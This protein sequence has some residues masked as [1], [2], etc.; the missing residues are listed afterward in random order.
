MQQ[1][2]PD[3][4][5]PIGQRISFA[6]RCDSPAEVDAVYARMIAAGHQGRQAPWDAF[7]GQ[8]YAMLT[9][10]DGNRVDLFADQPAA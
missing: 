10:P 5:R 8:R 4:V 6:C 3:W 9:D 2:Y 1:A 7:W